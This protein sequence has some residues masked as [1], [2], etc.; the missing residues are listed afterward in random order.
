[1]SLAS[2]VTDWRAGARPR[3]GMALVHSNTSVILGGTAARIARIPHIWH[4]REIYCRF[5]RSWQLIDG[6]SDGSALPSVSRVTAAQFD[7][8]ARIQVVYDGLATTVPR[9]TPAA[10]RTLGVPDDPP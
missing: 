3:R 9:T 10:R 1:M 4:V 2:H 7:P 5:G 8:D 6:Y